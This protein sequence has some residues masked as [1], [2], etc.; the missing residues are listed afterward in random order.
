[1]AAAMFKPCTVDVDADSPE[2]L[3]WMRQTAL[4]RKANLSG[5]LTAFCPDT[6]TDAA[7]RSQDACVAAIDAAM[8]RAT[9]DAAE[10]RAAA[11]TAV[12]TLRADA[13]Y[14]TARDKF[15]Q[16]RI[17]QGVACDTHDPAACKL[18]QDD[19]DSAASVMRGLLAEY[20]ID[21]RDADALA[22]R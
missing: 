2:K 13:R 15:H 8:P 5:A 18:A 22:L 10:R 17:Q 3:Q 9:A 14:A 1:M 21:L 20:H 12:A 4:N 19:A 16:L 7:L 11:T 6:V